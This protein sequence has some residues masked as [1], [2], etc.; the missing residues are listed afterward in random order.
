MTKNLLKSFILIGLFLFANLATA[1]NCPP[2]T[3]LTATSNPDGTATLQWT[4]PPQD[5]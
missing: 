1:Q 5:T 4:N 3:N 2:V